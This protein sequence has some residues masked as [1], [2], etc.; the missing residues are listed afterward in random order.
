MEDHQWEAARADA[1]ALGSR[2]AGI[3]ETVPLHLAGGRIL[4]A[5]LTAAYPMPHWATSAMDGYAVNGTGPWKLLRAHAA[6][7]AAADRVVLA[8]GEASAVVTGSLIPEGATAILRV[9]HSTL[10]GSLLSS[11]RTLRAGD[12]IRPSGTEASA[13]DLLAAAGTLLRAGVIATAA[14]AGHD[15]L[16]VAAVPP[17]HLVFTGDE[18]ITS[19]HPT[20]GQV[21]DG[22]SPVLPL[23]VAALGGTVASSTRI[24]D[25]LAATIAA[26]DGE[27]ARAAALVVTTG[28]TGFSD[29]DFVRAAV[30]AIGGREAISSV[31]MRPG[32][33]SMVAVL[34]DNRLLVALPGNPLAALMAVATLVDPILRGANGSALAE[35]HAATSATDFSKLPGRTRLIPARWVPAVGGAGPDAL[36][37]AEHVA[38]AMLRG[39]AAADAILVVGPDGATSGDPVP[40]LRLPW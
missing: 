14:V 16:P 23:V 19:G 21:R 34:P 24:G 31:A 7:P 36:A 17:V 25:T 8:D 10:Q 6:N 4:A 37:P 13:G 1:H 35:L 3:R 39:L 28:G 40:Y 38:P 11:E 15:E 9:E 32:H 20:P 33:P 22:F 5:D 27:D 29:R 18:V 12:D 30:S 26:I 2:I